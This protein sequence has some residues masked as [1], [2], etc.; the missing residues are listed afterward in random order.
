MKHKITGVFLIIGTTLFAGQ[1][2][3]IIDIEITQPTPIYK[4]FYLGLGVSNLKLNDESTD[5]S[6]T[7]NGLTLQ[8]GYK[9]DEY[10]SIEARYSRGITDVEYDRGST[11]FINNDDYPTKSSN[12]ALYLK[13]TYPIGDFNIYG[14]VGYGAVTYSDLSSKDRTENAIQWGLGTNYLVADKISAFIDYTLLYKGY[15]LDEYIPNSEL[16]SG[17]ITVGITYLF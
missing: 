1:N 11:G 5:E 10:F 17:M 16:D 6:F 2:R 15:G 4:N 3:D 12:I 13:P 9:Y 14:L 7:N 8:I